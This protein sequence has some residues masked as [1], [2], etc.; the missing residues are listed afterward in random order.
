MKRMPTCIVGLITILFFISCGKV[1][2]LNG[3]DWEPDLPP[4][5]SVYNR[6]IRILDLGPDNVPEGHRPLDG[7]DPLY[8]SL[9]KFS[10]VHLGYKTTERWDIAFS[11]MYRTSI[12]C[13]NGTKQGLGY[14]SS[15]RGGILV[16]DSAYSEVTT[17][18]DDNEFVYP[19]N[20]GLAY[21]EVYGGV[22]PGGHVWYTFFDYL[23]P[24]REPGMEHLYQHMMYP[25]SEDFAKVFPNAAATVKGPKTIII[26]T[27]S[28]NYVK[29]ETQSYYKGVLDPLKMRRG[30]DMPI[31]YIS[32][33]YM[34][35][36]AEEKRF[37]FVERHPKM[38]V[39]MTTKRTTTGG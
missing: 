23:N 2:D 38:T 17:V 35:I 28:G 6:E 15:A 19:G 22:V 3:F 25:V 24:D 36:K 30:T 27:A 31:P 21:A 10:S 39:N 1:Y 12:S 34:I 32:F 18:P 37:G 7:S 33:R 13:N 14:G 29:M 11:G 26:R 16:Y 9:E 20:V 8:F 4:S 5:D